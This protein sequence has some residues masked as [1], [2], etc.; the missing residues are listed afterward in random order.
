MSRVAIH[1]STLNHL[2]NIASVMKETA[3]SDDLLFITELIADAK[4]QMEDKTYAVAAR[5]DLSVVTSLASNEVEYA[6]EEDQ[7]AYSRV[8]N[9]S[10]G[11]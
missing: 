8:V 9:Q 4:S 7:E 2:I 11:E 1:D 3:D 10:C 6:D 5:S